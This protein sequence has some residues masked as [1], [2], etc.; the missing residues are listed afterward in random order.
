MMGAM[1]RVYT[2]RNP[3]DA[4]FVLGM[5]EGQGIQGRLR[6]EALFTTVDGGSSLMSLLPEIWVEEG[7]WERAH[8]LTEDYSRGLSQP[9]EAW[10]CPCGEWHEPQFGSCWNCGAERVQE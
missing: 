4:H 2:A 8:Q 5:L 6:G 9:G 10:S 3:T 7:A 1:K